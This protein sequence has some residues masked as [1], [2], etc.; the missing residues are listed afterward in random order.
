MEAKNSIKTFSARSRGEWRTWLQK[1]HAKEKNIWL[2]LYRKGSGVP[3]V[4][5]NEAVEEAICFGWIDSRPNKRDNQ[6]YYQ[7]FSRRNPDSNWSKANRLRAEKMIEQG[8]MAKAGLKMVE[9]AKRNGTWTALIDVQNAVVPDDLKQTLNKNRRAMTNFESFPPSSKRIILEWIAAAKR[10]ETRT[11]RIEET[12][13]LAAQN[14]RA[15]HYRQP[16]S[17]VKQ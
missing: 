3:T 15:N 5:Y 10:P 11:A 6:S 1:N 16:K 8:L 2:V 7:L 14:L 17:A 13:R 12:A 4:Q 9:L